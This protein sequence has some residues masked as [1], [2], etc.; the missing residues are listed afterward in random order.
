MTVKTISLLSYKGGVGKTCI[1]I[2]IAIH[3]IKQGNNVYLLDSDILA[4]SLYRYFK[5]KVVWF[6]DYMLDIGSLNN[7]IQEIDNLP[8]TPGKL[9]V[10]FTNPNN[11]RNLTSDSFNMLLAE[12]IKHFKSI[13]EE[14]YHIDYLILDNSPGENLFT[15]TLCYE[16]DSNLFITKVKSNDLL[17]VVQMITNLNMK[18]DSNCA[19]IAN[20]MPEELMNNETHQKMQ[21]ILQEEIRKRKKNL[22]VKFLGFIGMSSSIQRIEIEK[23]LQSVKTSSEAFKDISNIVDEIFSNPFSKNLNYE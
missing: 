23:A 9:F 11:K 16:I 20:Q 3:L 6:D 10:S 15:K 1:A 8:Q 21:D 19:I 13:L 4:P 12:K 5:V 18:P 22:K 7:C 14:Q 2:D 17:G